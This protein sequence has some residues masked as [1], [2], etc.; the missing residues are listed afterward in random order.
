MRST[1]DPLW[2]CFQVGADFGGLSSLLR[3]SRVC[4]LKTELT[5][6]PGELVVDREKEVQGGSKCE[7]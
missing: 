5:E 1:V 2:G 3:M 4:I 7:G 6:F